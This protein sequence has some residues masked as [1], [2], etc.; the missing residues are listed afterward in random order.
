MSPIRACP[1]LSFTVVQGL[2]DERLNACLRA[3]PLAAQPVISQLSAPIQPASTPTE[4]SGHELGS[5]K[6]VRKPSAR[7]TECRKYARYEQEAEAEADMLV[8]PA[9]PAQ[10]VVPAAVAQDLCKYHCCPK[11][12][13]HGTQ[14]KLC[15]KLCSMW[16]K[17][18]NKAG[19]TRLNFSAVDD[20]ETTALTLTLV[21]KP[22][23]FDEHVRPNLELHRSQHAGAALW[24]W[25]VSDHARRA[26]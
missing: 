18:K 5:R 17:H 6:R 23:Y 24:E 20:K 11:L 19:W 4:P 25:V 3:S 22:A 12:D 16:S 7:S 15:N 10:V 21:K 1:D 26:P 9:A 13:R 8:V 2:S 14:C